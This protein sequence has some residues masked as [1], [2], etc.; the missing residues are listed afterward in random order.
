MLKETLTPVVRLI[1]GAS[2]LLWDRKISPACAFAITRFAADGSDEPDVWSQL[3]MY[4]RN[5]IGC[6]RNNEKAMEAL[7]KSGKVNWIFTEPPV[8]WLNPEDETATLMDEDELCVER[9]EEDRL[10]DA[11][12]E[13]EEN[14][15]RARYARY[16]TANPGCNPDNP[17]VIP[18][19]KDYEDDES[20]ALETILRPIPY[21]YVDYEVVE[22][23]VQ[24]R[25]GRKIDHVRVRVST[26]L[27][28][29]EDADGE[30]YLPKKRFLGYEDYWF[31]IP[32]Y[33]SAFHDYQL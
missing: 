1:R 22:Q 14:E 20:L 2:A 8:T 29:T 12:L 30:L 26:H 32:G 17:I 6:E 9:A 11:F 23:R 16:D 31:D 15:D 24:V 10:V 4:Y 18:P 28:L 27:L 3:G 21:R 25:D 5:G 19:S 33:V 13:C 7:R